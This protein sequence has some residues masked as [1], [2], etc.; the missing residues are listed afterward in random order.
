MARDMSASEQ[1]RIDRRYIAAALR[2]SRKNLGLTST[3]PAVGTLIVR[4]GGNGPVIVGR[5]VTAIGGRPHAEAEA[6]AEAGDLARGATAYVTLEPCAHHGRTPPCAN[7]LVNAGI[8]RVVGAASDPDPRVSGR[9]YAI[10]R[11]AG[12]EVKEGVLA[13]EAADQL[14]GYM[15]RSLRKRP[16]VIL[17]LALS[18]DGMIGRR[19]QGQ[20]EITGQVA[21][22]QVHVMRAEIDAILVGIGT[23]LAD[24]PELTVRLP[25]LRNRSPARIVLDR[26]ARLPATSKLARSAHDVPVFVA[27]CPEGDPKNRAELER[28]GVKFLAT[29]TYDGRVALP[30]L[31]ED[32]ANQGMS[33]IIVEGGADTARAFLDEGLVDRIA[34]FSG[35]EAIGADGIAAPIGRDHIPA[36]FSLVREARFGEDTFAEWIREI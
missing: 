3:N 29:E 1:D 27:A 15:N 32:L 4:D 13:R 33:R 22:R 19:G 20:I 36:G 35:P 18:A 5:G 7:A 9:G 17:K 2:L 11:G 21:R 10:L 31:L 6:L 12:I 26:L 14:A 16:E 25:G 23:A 28:A 24:D 34:L 30:E 8:T